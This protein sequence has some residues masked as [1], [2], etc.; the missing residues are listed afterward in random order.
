MVMDL[1]VAIII[2]LVK[3]MYMYPLHRFEDLT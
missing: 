1:F 2:Y 3:M